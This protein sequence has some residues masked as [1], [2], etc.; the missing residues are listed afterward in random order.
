MTLVHKRSVHVVLN[1]FTKFKIQEIIIRLPCKAVFI[2]FMKGYKENWP[3]CLL[4]K[5]KGLQEMK[6]R[7]I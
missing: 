1:G 3:L 4:Y 2:N 7:G 5:P 6:Y